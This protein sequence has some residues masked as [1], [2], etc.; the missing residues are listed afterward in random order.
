MA[1]GEA[2]KSNLKRVLESGRFAV[3]AELGP[4][5]SVDRGVIEKKT[6]IP[7]DWVDALNVTDNQAAVTRIPSL[8]VCAILRSPGLKPVLQITARDR[9]LLVIQS[10]I[11]GAAA[12]GI[13]NVLC[14]TGTTSLGEMI[15]AREQSTTST[16]SRWWERVADER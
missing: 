10:D 5:K 15:P 1:A 7:S 8:A 14:C 3:T 13:R 16:R 9:N 12:L 2:G 11:L 6:K 4:P